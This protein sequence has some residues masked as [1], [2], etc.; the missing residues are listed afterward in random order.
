[1]RRQKPQRQKGKPV[2]AQKPGQP[3]AARKKPMQERI[4]SAPILQILCS[5][6]VS[7]CAY[8]V[9]VEISLVRQEGRIASTP[10]SLA[11]AETM[12]AKPHGDLPGVRT[13][14]VS[15]L[16]PRGEGGQGQL[17]K[18]RDLY[19]QARDAG[20]P[21]ALVGNNFGSR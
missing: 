8:Y 10:S 4:I 21:G 14:Y 5:A 2:A 7:M 12:V 15:L 3:V 16:L 1:M 6:R 20:D 13:A 18:A 19:E 11:S 9:Y 17:A